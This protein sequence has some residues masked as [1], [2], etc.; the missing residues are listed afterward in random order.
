VVNT[1]LKEESFLRAQTFLEL[2][3]ARKKLS[4]LSP[5]LTTKMIDLYKPI[6]HSKCLLPQDMLISGGIQVL[7]VREEG[8]AASSSPQVPVYSWSSRSTSEGEGEDE[9]VVKCVLLWAKKGS[10]STSPR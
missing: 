4:S 10:V 1:G 7:G 9:V 5:V 8:F 3:M 2:Q 6:V